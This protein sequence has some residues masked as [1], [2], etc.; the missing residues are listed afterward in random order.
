MRKFSMIVM[1][2][3]LA[4]CSTIHSLDRNAMTRFEIK[5]NGDWTMAATTA[6]NYPVDS[7]KAEAIRRN[8]ISEHARAN[9]CTGFEI[10]SREWTKA[11]GSISESV[12]TL[13]YAGTC[14][15]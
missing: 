11:V 14:S 5:D 15:R 6:A 8:W 9:G 1:A 3:A 10:T 13:N 12:G 7:E 4:G 2:A